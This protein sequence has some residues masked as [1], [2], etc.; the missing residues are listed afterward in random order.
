M[1]KLDLRMFGKGSS[2]GGGG[3]GGTNHHGSA[4][5]GGN[6]YSS[7]QTGNNNSGNKSSSESKS[8]KNEKV[9][10]INSNESYFI[11]ATRNNREGEAKAVKGSALEKLVAAGELHYDENAEVWKDKN[12]RRYIIRRK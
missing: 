7:E 2:G 6:H 12:G 9:S 3:G 1:I 8:R 11:S 10:S 5:G 4:G